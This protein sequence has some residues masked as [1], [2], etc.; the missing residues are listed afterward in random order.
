M[1][2]KRLVGLNNCVSN[3]YEYL[4]HLKKYGVISTSARS[5]KEFID[6]AKEATDGTVK[7]SD[8]MVKKALRKLVDSNILIKLDRGFYKLNR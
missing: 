5:R 3:L 7:Y 4:T 1:T 2:D 8:A 6:F